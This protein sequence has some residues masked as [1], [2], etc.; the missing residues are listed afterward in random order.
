MPNPNKKYKIALV[1]DCLAQGGAEKVMAL[2]SIYFEKQNIEVHNCIF[3]DFVSYNYSGT[4]LNLG[5]VNPNS[6]SIVRKFYRFFSFKKFINSNNFDFIIDFRVRPSFLLEFLLSKFIYPG[7]VIYTVHS[8]F[9]DF[10][11]PKNKWVSLLI[12]NNKKIITVCNAIKNKI[13]EDK[14]LYNLQAIYNPIDFNSISTLENEFDITEKYIL[15]VGRMND[16][17]KQIDQLILAYSK[18]DM[19]KQ[20]IKLIILGDGKNKQSYQELVQKLNLSD[21]VIFKGI[22]KNP[23]PYFKNAF[24]L[25]LSSK[26]EGFPNVIIESLACKTPVISFDCFSGPNEIITNE[27]NGLLVEDQNFEKLTEAMNQ[28]I[29]NTILYQ[30]CKTNALKSVQKFSVEKIGQ[31]W[32]DL[33]EF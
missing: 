9:L 18:S 30:K 22:V 6:V 8:G 15:A 21:L 2:L 25:L 24:F 14:S 10:Y 27:I 5:K 26:N 20:S 29:H 16:D 31:Q 33:M 3:I 4:L 28:F 11:F 7:N 17:I 1:G 12:Y 23:F 32:L 19:P 13:K